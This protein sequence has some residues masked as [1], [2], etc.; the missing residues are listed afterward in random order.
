MGNELRNLAGFATALVA[1]AA[2][3]LTGIAVIN[4]FKDSNSVDNTTADLFITGLGFFGTFAG[5]LI[6]AVIGKTII[7]L[8]K[9][10]S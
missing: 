6:L 10:D 3:T 2:I 1:V 7:G 9:K 5:I 4:G 8:F